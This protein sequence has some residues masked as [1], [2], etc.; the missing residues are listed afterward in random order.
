MIENVV[1]LDKELRLQSFPK[2]EES[3]RVAEIELV[4]VRRPHCVSSNIEWPRRAQ[5]IT[6]QD[7]V[8]RNVL[9]VSGRDI[10]QN[11]ELIV[12]SQIVHR[13][14]VDLA[15]GLPD[16]AQ[17]RSIW[18]VDGTVAAVTVSIGRVRDEY[19]PLVVGIGRRR[20]VDGV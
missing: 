8:R 13:A 18:P 6:I 14:I 11:C 9:L 10:R 7:T 16:S 2:F 17:R 15:Q 5:R 20:V 19:R 1:R 4:N 3:S 12:I